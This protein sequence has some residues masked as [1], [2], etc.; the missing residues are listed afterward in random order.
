MIYTIEMIHHHQRVFNRTLKEDDFKT[1]ADAKR[2]FTDYIA[3]MLSEDRSGNYRHESYLPSADGLKYFHEPSSEWHDALPDWW[4]GEGFYDE[5]DQLILA[6]HYPRDESIADIAMIS[7][8]DYTYELCEAE[9]VMTIDV[10]RML[11][12]T[13]PTVFAMIKRG[14]LSP[15]KVANRYLFLK[16]DIDAL[17]P[18]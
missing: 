16:R 9:Y 1:Y 7:L 10:C 4:K 15:T 8:G 2:W 5:A 12:V 18:R 11:Q 13:R 14:D 6:Y 17:L 3:D